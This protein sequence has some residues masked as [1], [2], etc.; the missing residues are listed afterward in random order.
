METPPPPSPPSVDVTQEVRFA[1]VM[2]GGVSLC[3]YINGV[4]QELLELSRVTAMDPNSEELLHAP[5]GA[6]AVYRRIAQYLDSDETQTALLREGAPAAPVRTRFIVDVLSGTSAGGLNSLFLAKALANDQDMEGL[7]TLWMEEGEIT[8]LL[9]DAESVKGE[10]GLKD[11]TEPASLLNSQRMYKKLLEALDAMDFP[12]G[13]AGAA[14]GRNGG[15]PAGR[16]PSP[17]VN[18]LD[19]YITTTDLSGL[20]VQLK[21]DNTV[22][23]EQRHRNVFHFR[24][25]G[26]YSRN[27]PK[28]RDTPDANDFAVQHNPFLAFTGRCT[29]AFP[30]AFEPMRLEDIEDVI[31]GWER[32]DLPEGEEKTRLRATWA[33]RFYR[34]YAEAGCNF[35]LTSFGDGGYLDNKPFSYATQ[36][37]MRRR[38]ELPVRRKLIYIDPSPEPPPVAR[39]EPKQYNFIENTLAA[40]I[41]L[42]RYETIREDIQAVLD[43]NKLLET[44]DWLTNAL[45]EDVIRRSA[46]RQERARLAK[47]AP[48]PY[49]QRGLAKRIAEDGIGYGTY[50][51][52]R[53]LAVTRNL[54]NIVS[55]ASGFDPASDECQAIRWIVRVWRDDNFAEEPESGSVPYGSDNDFPAGAGRSRPRSSQNSFLSAFDL[56][57]RMRRIFFLQRRV[58]TLARVRPREAAAPADASLEAAPDCRE[59]LLDVLDTPEKIAA[60]RQQVRELK[61]GLAD[62]LRILVSAERRLLDDKKLAEMLAACLVPERER[63]SRTREEIRVLA[64]AS[65]RVILDDPKQAEALYRANVSAFDAIA[66]QVEKTLRAEFSESRNLLRGLQEPGAESPLARVGIVEQADFY[67]RFLPFAPEEFDDYDAAV[68]PIQF[69]TDASEANHVDVV[70]ISPPDARQLINERED[71]KGRRKLA[72]TAIFSFGAFLARFWR[73]NDMLWGRLDAAEVLVR[74]LLQNTPAAR[75][76]GLVEELVAEAHREILTE[77]L[78][79]AQREELWN[80]ISEAFS[81]TSEARAKM[82]P[83]QAGLRTAVNE[84]LHEFPDLDRRLRT[85]LRFAGTED[86]EELREYFQTSYEVRRRLVVTEQLRLATR[87]GRIVSRMLNTLARQ[88]PGQE[89]ER[90]IARL[91]RIAAVMWGVVEISIP[92]T[93]GWHLWEDWRYRFYTTSVV[94]V[95][96]GFL[97][98]P[99][100]MAGL[101]AFAL[102]LAVDAVRWQVGDWIHG[103]KWFRKALVLVLGLL[104]LAVLGLA[105]WKVYELFFEAY[106]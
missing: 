17:H 54:A 91:S 26:P 105:G 18:D 53:V 40:L 93:I 85:V 51:R 43:R 11:P 33:R 77:T 76:T 10:P 3:I 89:V 7:K 80:F 2:Y 71:P 73:E 16:Q 20:P 49:E 42:P 68:F 88:R 106:R 58:G 24:Y 29:S 39:R 13:N 84:L 9:N 60:F 57:Y 12:R 86:D 83:S 72:G 100:L 62:P 46:A 8:R 65:L 44:V 47:T 22:A 74:S 95:V 1:V 79:R 82:P 104:L 36:T 56:D 21:L 81:A 94:L 59:E 5:I 75:E 64:K 30:F 48:T 41:E 4:A 102:T 87:A 15:G 23:T 32:Y 63:A 50:H 61:K 14:N 66:R 103:T 6:G 19:C 90:H 31:R 52:L 98:Q 99:V 55:R 101:A 97:W 69:G 92:R 25:R 34:D 37:L 27:D 78:T 70:R 45:N 28:Y 38:A 35:A 67:T 96:V